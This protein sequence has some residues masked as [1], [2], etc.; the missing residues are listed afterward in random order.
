[1]NQRGYATISNDTAY[2]DNSYPADYM[3]WYQLMKSP[4]GLRK[5]VALALSEIC[6][7]SLSAHLPLSLAL[8]AERQELVLVVLEALGFFELPGGI[9]APGDDQLVDFCTCPHGQ[10]RR[11]ARVAVHHA[12]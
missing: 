4:D 9:V 5:R 8:E 1:M 11:S 6:V 3:I 2:Y 10:V 12:L 7:V